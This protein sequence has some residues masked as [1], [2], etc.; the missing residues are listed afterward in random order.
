MTKLKV[1]K[2]N[3]TILTQMGLYPYRCTEPSAQLKSALFAFY[4]LLWTEAIFGVFSSS[5]YIYEHWPRLDIVSQPCLIVVGDSVCF[6]MVLSVGLKLKAVKVL[7]LKLQEI[8]DAG[9]Y[10]LLFLIFSVVK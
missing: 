8:V 7:H 9:E 10:F 3:Q 2:Y 4:F 6:V 5:A 1:L